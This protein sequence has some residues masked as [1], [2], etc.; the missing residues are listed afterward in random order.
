MG[1]VVATP[2]CTLAFSP[3]EPMYIQTRY[4]LSVIL[5][6]PQGDSRQRQK[7]YQ[8]LTGQAA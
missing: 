4:L 1:N 8:K 7:N 5:A 6:F 3:A 2:V